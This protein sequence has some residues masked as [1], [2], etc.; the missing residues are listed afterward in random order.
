MLQMPALLLVLLLL[1]LTKVM[2]TRLSLTLLLGLPWLQ[3]MMKRAPPEPPRHRTRSP[4]S[5]LWT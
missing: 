3:M 1:H 4:E 5:M 2:K